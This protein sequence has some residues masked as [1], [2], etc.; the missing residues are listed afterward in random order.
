MKREITLISVIIFYL[1]I[2]PSFGQSTKNKNPQQHEKEAYEQKKELKESIRKGQTPDEIIA[3]M[4]EPEEIETFRRKSDVI[5]VWYYEH[6]DVRIE[7]ANGLVSTWFLR[8]MPD[9]PAEAKKY[10]CDLC[11]KEEKDKKDKNNKSD[12]KSSKD[13]KPQMK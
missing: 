10:K 4:G 9:R 11:E 2:L 12:K 3:I 1:M 8:F 7:F 6:R 5:T 13:T